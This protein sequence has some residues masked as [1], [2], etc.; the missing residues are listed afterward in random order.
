[1]SMATFEPGARLGD[2]RLDALL[3][4]GATGLVFQASQ[5]SDQGRPVALKILRAEQ[6]ADAVARARFVREARLARGID[7]PHIVPILDLGESQGVTFLVMPLYEIGSLARRLRTVERLTLDET[8]DLS[9]QLGRGLDALHARSIVHRDVKPSNVLLGLAGVAA[10]ADFGLA[11]ATDSTRLTQEGQLLG[12][13]HYL[14]P[15]L[16][17]GGDATEASDIYALGCLLYE[18]VVGRPPF[19]GRSPAEVGFAHLTD[20][21][22]DP[23]EVRSEL[24]EQLAD[25]L[26]FA[27]DKD[28]SRRPTSATA[29]SRMLDVAR[30]AAPA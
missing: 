13:A 2:Y 14:A 5:L 21:P 18:C 19:T 11:L 7:S 24:P 10:L 6:T 29:L 27:L 9:A 23:R 12:T 4:E 8:V 26:R 30:R 28:P 15:E 16:I 17:E 22:P 3:G 20:P 25:A 1:M